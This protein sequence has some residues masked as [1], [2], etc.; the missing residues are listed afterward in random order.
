ML[1]KGMHGATDSRDN[2]G[3]R[4]Q[5]QLLIATGNEKRASHVAESVHHSCRQ[6]RT[7]CAA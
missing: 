7:L 6:Q 5:F 1:R 4:Y 3:R 2:T